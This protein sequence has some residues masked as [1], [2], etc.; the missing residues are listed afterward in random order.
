TVNDFQEPSRIRCEFVDLFLAENA[1]RKPLSKITSFDFLPSTVGFFL[2][3]R[4]LA[5][6]S[7]AQLII[8]ATP[9]NLQQDFRI[10]QHD[11]F[12]LRQSHELN[13]LIV[14]PGGFGRK[15]LI[16]ARNDTDRLE[17]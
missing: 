7:P 3:H 1:N 5:V 10:V 11:A 16:T 17:D 8:L 13:Q 12:V 6:K 14:Y 9:V 4:A 15:I 2:Q